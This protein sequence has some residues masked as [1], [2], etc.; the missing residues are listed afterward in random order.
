MVAPTNSTWVFLRDSFI[1]AIYQEQSKALKTTNKPKKIKKKR[2][3]NRLL[4]NL[5]LDKL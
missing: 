4:M 2:K 3:F 5:Q 1:R